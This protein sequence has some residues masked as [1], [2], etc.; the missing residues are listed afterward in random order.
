MSDGPDLQTPA[1]KSS[2]L[3]KI[4]V[5]VV[6]VGAVAGGGGFLISKL[7][8]GSAKAATPAP[9]ATPHV[10]AIVSLDPLIVN[11]DEAGMSRY[12]KVT[13]DLELAT[14]LD[15]SGKRLLPRLRDR[16]LLY[17]TAL[18]TDQVQK[19]KTKLAIKDQIRTIAEEVFG[20][21]QIR[22]VYLKE[23]IVQ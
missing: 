18:T 17:L 11:L 9:A 16:A 14:E 5:L 23:L 22:A 20:K 4:L 7:S 6:V 15:D 3:P 19:S 2:K 21:S 1:I 13:V 10:G 8:S 12:L